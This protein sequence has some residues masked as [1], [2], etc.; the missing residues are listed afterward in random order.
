MITRRSFLRLSGQGGLLVMALPSCKSKKAPVENSGDDETKNLYDSTSSASPSETTAPPIAG[1]GGG[2]LSAWIHIAENDVITY[3]VPEAEMGQGVHTAIPMVISGEL[4]GAWTN[5]V[6]TTAPLDS[7]A[8]GR[9]S[10]GGSTSIRTGFDRFR[11]VGATARKLLISAAAEA[12]GA[13]EGE[14]DTAESVVHWKLGGKSLRFGDVA[15][16]ASALPLAT[17]APLRKALVLGAPTLRLDSFAK[18]TGTAT[19][20]MDIRR[21]G[22][23]IGKSV[24]SPSVGGTVKSFDDSKAR[25]VEGVRDVVQT[26]SGVVV[27]ADHTWAAMKGRDALQVTWDE[28]HRN[29][30]QASIAEAMKKALPKGKEAFA[31]G[32]ATAL[33][34]KSAT[35]VEAEYFVPY[36][37]HAPME[38]ENCTVE[39][40]KDRCDIWTGTQSGTAAGQAAAK[41]AG[42]DVEKVFVNGQLLGGGFGRR[43]KADFVEEAVEAAKASGRTVKLIWDREQDIRGYHYRPAALNTFRAAVDPA[44]GKLLAWEHRIASPS[45]L[46]QFGPLRGGIDGS[47]VEG[48]IKYAVPDMRLTWSDVEMPISTWFWRSVGHSQNGF[49]VDGFMNEAAKAAGRDPLEFR[50]DTQIARLGK[51]N[52]IEDNPRLRAVM[53]M[54]AEKASWGKALPEGHAHGI[55]ACESF[56]SFCAQVAEV[57]IEKGKPRVHKVTCVIDCGQT[58]NPLTIEAQMESG[59]VYGLS[60]AL[61]GNIQFEN[62]GVVE[63]NFDRYQ[64]LR[65]NEMPQVNTTIVA[66]S[67]PHGG[68]GEPATPPIAGAVAGAL[69]ALTG[70]PQ[71][72]LPLVP[73]IR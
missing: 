3:Y 27:L 42:L 25:E 61:Y 39:I 37:A 22:M 45:I 11:A 23:L 48:C 15:T 28:P 19:Y 1:T 32:R 38:P 7:Q 72:R 4:G 68:V 29:V 43:S 12:M 66:S 14:C 55:S 36:L 64:V 73:G 41:I 16:K 69:F 17:D 30:S 40:S 52:T 50:L 21:P 6:A 10:T 31:S 51:D 44:K 56:G 20:G 5:A 60:A 53:E 70:A 26:S 62:G 47:S 58:I 35:V 54:A 46:S 57:S 2:M 59:I 71:R 34:A 49:V 9:Q 67:E 33:L 13:P 8:F 18:V 63:G 65:M 24:H